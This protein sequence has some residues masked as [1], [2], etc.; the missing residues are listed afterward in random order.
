M[1]DQEMAQQVKG[2]I[3]SIVCIIT[4]ALC[5]ANGVSVLAAPV[6]IA[7]V[8]GDGENVQAVAMVDLLT[9]ELS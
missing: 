5:I 2:T 4:L 9:A 7:L 1:K 3:R 8:A 6:R